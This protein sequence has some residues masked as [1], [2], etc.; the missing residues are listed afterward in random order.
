[1]SKDPAKDQIQG[2]AGVKDEEAFSQE[3]LNAIF[4]V[5]PSAPDRLISR[6]SGS[7]EFKE[8]FNWSNRDDYARTMAG[9][10]NAHGGYLVFG[11]G[12]KP[13][14]MVGLKS[15]NFEDIDPSSISEFLNDLFSPEIHWSMR[16]YE[17]GGLTFGLIHVGEHSQKP[18]VARKNSGKTKEGDVLYRYRGRTERIK[19][20]ELRELL[21]EQRRR[22]QRTWLRQLSRIARIGVS[23][24]AVM[25][26][27]TGKVTGRGGTF[28][29]DAELL[30]KLKFIKEGQFAEKAG[31]PA[32]R[33]VGDLQPVG[34]HLIQP[35]KTKV[36][37]IAIRTPEIIRAFL[38]QDSVDEP[39]NFVR[40]VCF[41]TSGFLPVYHFLRQAKLSM[42]EAVAVAQSVKSTAG[43][44]T[45]LLKRLQSGATLFM[46]PPKGKSEAAQRKLY[47]LNL[48]RAGKRPGDLEGIELIRCVCAVHMLEP[49]EVA[50]HPPFK[51]LTQWFDDHFATGA[52]AVTD[53]IR[54][55]IA[56]VDEALNREAIK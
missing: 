21:E 22:D 24:A 52:A 31:A 23:N 2:A 50:A 17:L 10:A 25:D 30:P 56:Y 19:Y 46:P 1:V 18:V 3:A 7:L 14:K 49:A 53:A 32:L 37:T 36:R 54:R 33:L 51:L 26:L 6:E 42:T 4:R 11:V 41:E 38:Q 48:L 35:V 47:Y 9:F 27:E 8:S 29:I 13:R 45:T 55:V 40:Q 12:N 16:I 28:V 5:S 44:R 34:E 20:P 43:G 39:L 15:A